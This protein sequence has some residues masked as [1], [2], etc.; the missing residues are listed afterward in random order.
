MAQLVLIC[1]DLSPPWHP[2]PVWLSECCQTSGQSYRLSPWSPEAWLAGIANGAWQK[3]HRCSPAAP[4]P[5]HV[6]TEHFSGESRNLK[7]HVQ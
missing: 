2:K 7:S 6:A 5:P 4:R 1:F 3:S